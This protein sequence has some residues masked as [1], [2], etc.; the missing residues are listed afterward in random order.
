MLKPNISNVKTAVIFNMEDGQ[1][2]QAITGA[3]SK[4]LEDLRPRFLSDENFGIIEL[5]K[6]MAGNLDVR[7]HYVDITDNNT[8]KERPDNPAVID[9]TVIKADGVDYC[10]I[11][12]LPKPTYID[13]IVDPTDREYSG[14]IVEDGV[15]EVTAESVITMTFYIMSGIYK[16]AVFTVKAE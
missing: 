3:E 15:L 5:P 9:K 10:T 12:N 13:I 4:P 2:Y 14:T 6:D 8:V 11:S 16:E 7:I 1:I